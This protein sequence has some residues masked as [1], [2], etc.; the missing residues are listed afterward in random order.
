VTKA[1]PGVAIN[2]FRVGGAS[3]TNSQNAT[4]PTA[5]KA[6]AATTGT[7]KKTTKKADNAAGATTGGN[8]K[9]GKKGS[10]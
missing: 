3:A 9:T 6:A 7:N 2:S 8:K 5:V 4:A 1:N 10:E